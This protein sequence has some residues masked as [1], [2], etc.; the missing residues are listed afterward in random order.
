MKRAFLYAWTGPTTLIGLLAAGLTLLTGGRLACVEGVLEVHG[1]FAAFV[2]RRLVPLPNGA[3][4]L[5]LGHVVLG[6][7]AA[8]LARTRR[9]ERV[10]V[11]QTERWGP[12]FIPAYFVASFLAWRAGGDAYRD[13]AFER[14]AYATDQKHP[15]DE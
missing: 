3:A 11:R 12:L 5:T 1:G 13:N 15:S 7:T 4:A 2:L 10:H 9:H 8:D 14:E 6:Q